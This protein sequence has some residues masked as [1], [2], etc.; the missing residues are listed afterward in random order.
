R[1]FGDV[2]FP[3]SSLPTNRSANTCLGLFHRVRRMFLLEPRQ[4][5][6]VRLT[7]DLLSFNRLLTSALRLLL[8]VSRRSC[9]RCGLRLWL[10]CLLSAWRR[11]LLSKGTECERE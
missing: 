4:A 6:R 3:R 1:N 5:F 9:G 8:G 2:H 11:G 7:S 10:R